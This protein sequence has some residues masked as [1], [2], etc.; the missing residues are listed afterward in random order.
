MVS[1]RR[2]LVLLRAVPVWVNVMPIICGPIMKLYMTRTLIPELAWYR[3]A[4]S[5]DFC[6]PSNFFFL[7]K[8]PE[9]FLS[10]LLPLTIFP[11]FTP[12]FTLPFPLTWI[13]LSC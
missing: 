7:S 11:F 8:A 2:G 12:F 3:Q 10:V 5:T 9:I 1:R 4:V 13:A 6:Q